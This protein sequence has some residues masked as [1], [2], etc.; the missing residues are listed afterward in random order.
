M[1]LKKQYFKCHIYDRR[2]MFDKA[3]MYSQEVNSVNKIKYSKLD[4]F[5]FFEG[6]P[7]V[8]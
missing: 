8:L 5:N 2:N 6:N 1:L 4:S 7:R 3:I